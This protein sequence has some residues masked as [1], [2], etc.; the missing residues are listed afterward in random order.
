[1]SRGWTKCLPI[2]LWPSADR[3]AWERA[4]RLGNP[5]ED[6]GIA[7]SWSPA[8]R[9][10]TIVGYGRY[11]FFLKDRNELDE[12][13]RPA[14]RIT[15]ERLTAYLEHL[16]RLNRGHTIQ[17]RIQEL[18]DAMRALAP[19]HDWSFV[20][21]AAGRLRADTI[22][23]R[24][25][26]ERLLAIAEVI[27]EGSVLLKRAEENANLSEIERAV[28]YRDGVLLTFLAYH[29]KRLRNL[30]S[31]RIGHHLI[32]RGKMFIL[33]IDASETK[34]R[35]FSEEEVSKDLSF[36]LR[37]YIETY[38]PVLLRARGRWHAPALDRLWVS[39]DGSPCSDQTLRN[40]VKKHLVGPNGEPISPHLFRTMAPTSVSIEAPGSVDI[41]PA[42]LNHRS[43]RTAERY[44]NLAT[45]LD[46]S[47]VFATA[48][49]S[50]RMK[51]RLEEQ[52]D[53][54]K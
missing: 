47:R 15:P 4:I 3:A 14:E 27:A 7:A 1:M 36:A 23:A 20:N 51:L 2:T 29:P 5:F 10:K 39:R 50:I 37:R 33:K 25:K 30:S 34:A 42:I 40:I 16:K 6:G 28:L 19:E 41:I 9:R 18:G 8:T 44:Y 32:Q 46:A 53:R 38:R 54:Y 12:T 45:S 17:C 26:R 35:Q 13:A 21:R 48:L 43:H 31:L 22:P 11:L 52:K 24:D 49:D